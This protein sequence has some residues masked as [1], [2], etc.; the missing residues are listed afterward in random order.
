MNE[1]AFL[2]NVSKLHAPEETNTEEVYSTPPKVTLPPVVAVEVYRNDIRIVRASQPYNGGGIRRACTEISA[3]SIKNAQ[4]IISNSEPELPSLITLT[5]PETYPVD[6][7]VVKAHFRALKERIRRKFGDY[8]YFCCQ[9]YQARGAPHLH[10]AVNI[11]LRQCGEITKLHR[12]A[13]QRRPAFETHKPTQDWLFLAWSEIVSNDIPELDWWGVTGEDVEAMGQAYHV[14][15]SGVSWEMMR[16]DN[17]AKLY[18]VKELSALKGYQKEIPDDFENPG[19]HFL[20][21]PDMKPSPI[22][23]LEATE[24]IIRQLL[25]ELA[26]K[27]LPAANRPLYKDLW[28][29][30]SELVIKLLETGA[31]LLDPERLQ[32]LR[33]YTDLRCQQFTDWAAI[34]MQAWTAETKRL[35]DALNYWRHRQRVIANSLSWE[36]THGDI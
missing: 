6:G 10:I 33:T 20:Y 2:S 25:H 12:G 14:Y 11:D 5:Y 29:V 21:S 9:E 3:A 26:W 13:G 34:E 35:V 28:N 16:K 30:A 36:A 18:L 4:H 1:Q 15:N 24:Q 27:W 19:R 17:G 8:S 23:T 7:R 32:A 31:N 22:V